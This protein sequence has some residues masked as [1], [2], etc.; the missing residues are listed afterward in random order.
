VHVQFVKLFVVSASVRLASGD[1]G[2]LQRVPDSGPSTGATTTANVTVRGAGHAAEKPPYSYN[3][4]IMMAIRSSPDERLT[5]N[6]IYEFIIRNFP[7][8]RENKQGWQNS[9][10]H[11]LSLNKCFVKVPR[12]YDDPGKGNYWMLDP[13]ADDVFI[14]GTTGKLRRRTSSS[15]RGR[16]SAIRRAVGVAATAA[17]VFGHHPHH[18]HHHAMPAPPLS[19]TAPS[20]PHPASLLHQ[21]QLHHHHSPP[22][23]LA[24]VGRCW[25]AAAFVAAAVAASERMLP[26]SGALDAN[27]ATAAGLPELSAVH[28]HQQQLSTAAVPRQ[29]HQSGDG[30]PESTTSSGPELRSFSVDRLLR[31]DCGSLTMSKLRQQ[32][33]QQLQQQLVID[34]MADSSTCKPPLPL[35]SQDVHCNSASGLT[36]L[37]NNSRLV[38]PLQL[39]RPVTSIMQS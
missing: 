27:N 19:A 31:K 20:Q 13:S 9:I 8:Y 11:N 3:A 2:K 39:Q 14:G 16:L 32:Q 24:A 26:W 6:G 12:H 15:T 36:Q 21:Y 34:K 37:Q 22:A 18:E 35:T 23:A 7:Y 10:R 4:M 38:L 1:D 29:P 17:G 28:H 5:L 30:D 25:N 33:Q